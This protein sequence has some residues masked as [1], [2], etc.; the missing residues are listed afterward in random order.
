LT[1]NCRE[2]SSPS[3]GTD[4]ECGSVG[5][6]PRLGR[7]GPRSESGHSDIKYFRYIVEFI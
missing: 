2:G 4:T 1:E 7:G 3:P 5:R 6:A